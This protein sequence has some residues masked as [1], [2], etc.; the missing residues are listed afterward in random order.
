MTIIHH[1]DDLMIEDRQKT[2]S[3]FYTPQGEA[4]KGTSDLKVFCS[5]ELVARGGAMSL[6]T[7]AR[8]SFLVRFFFLNSCFAQSAGRFPLLDCK[9]SCDSSPTKGLGGF[10][11]SYARAT[12]WK[13]VRV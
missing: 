10:D 13:N 6:S 8:K 12:H 5:R 7:V 9:G 1:D 4:Q 2:F 3:F 11:P